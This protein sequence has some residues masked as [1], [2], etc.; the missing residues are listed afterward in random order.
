VALLK[1][2]QPEEPWSVEGE[3]E[4]DAGDAAC[5]RPVCAF[6]AL[7][8]GKAVGFARAQVDADVPAA[9]RRRLW[10]AVAHDARRRGIGTALL[11]MVGEAAAAGGATEF[12]VSTSLAEPD[13]LAFALARGFR[14]VEAEHELHLDLE[15]FDP[16]GFPRPGSFSSLSV[17]QQADRGWFESYYRLHTAVEAGVPWGLG[18]AVPCRE[19][20]RRRHVDAAEALHEG[21]AVALAGGE[22]VGLC[23]MRRS[24]EDA[25]TAYEE[26]TGVLPGYRG[27]GLGTALVAAAAGWAKEQGY[28]RLLTSTSTA[29]EAMLRTARRL[30]FALAGR[31]SH[32]LGPATRGGVPSGQE[33]HR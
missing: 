19:A 16:G 2:A 28:R 26:L 14:E 11:D 17:L 4:A 33:G 18:S 6:F 9:G 8:A 29:N 31:W 25:R 27:R 22:W 24:G 32:L 23:E 30:G 1:E 10:V 3:E 15:A 20:F 21:T 5:G 13:G 12:H 7:A